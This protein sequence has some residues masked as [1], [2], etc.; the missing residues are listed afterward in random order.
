MTKNSNVQL[1]SN[2]YPVKV[3]GARIDFIENPDFVGRVWSRDALIKLFQFVHHMPYDRSILEKYAKAI[4]GLSEWQIRRIETADEC[5]FAPGE[6]PWGIVIRD[7]SIKEVCRCNKRDCIRFTEC[8]P[9]ME[10]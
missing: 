3:D 6:K 7:D 4:P 10:T 9:E 2:I 5:S 8:R 1:T